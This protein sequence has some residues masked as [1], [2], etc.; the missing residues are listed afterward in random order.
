M[1][2]HLV[3]VDPGTRYLSYAVVSKDGQLLKAEKFK[4]DTEE[5]GT[6]CMHAAQW[7]R[8]LTHGGCNTL[9]VEH[10]QVRHRSR[11]DPNDIVDLATIA[12]A[13]CSSTSVNTTL[14]VEPNRWKG[15]VPKKI[16]QERLLGKLPLMW[17]NKIDTAKP[18]HDI[19]DAV[20]IAWWAIQSGLV[21]IQIGA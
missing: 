19:I 7:M 17:I 8:H 3:T 18:D 5:L 16:H 12:G 6:R 1:K 11:A 4:L 14:L 13:C 2:P 20:G 15:S 10:P 9:I 21:E